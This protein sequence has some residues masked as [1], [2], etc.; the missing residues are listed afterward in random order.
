VTAM[1]LLVVYDV[2]QER[3][4][5]VMRTCREYLDHVQNSVF[6]GEISLADYKEWEL[7]INGIIDKET[8]SVLV[9][10]LWPKSFKKTIIGIEKRETSNFV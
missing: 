6:E 7:R 2:A 3:V 1:Y 5:K 8:D 10:E 4:G 9:Y